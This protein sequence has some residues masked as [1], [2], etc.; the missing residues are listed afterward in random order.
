MSMENRPKLQSMVKT[1]MYYYNTTFNKHEAFYNRRSKSR[2]SDGS[3]LFQLPE[4]ARWNLE[5]VQRNTNGTCTYL[6][7]FRG[8]HNKGLRVEDHKVAMKEIRVL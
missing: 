6:D 8:W 1:K 2:R 3:G 4:V 5:S 7:V